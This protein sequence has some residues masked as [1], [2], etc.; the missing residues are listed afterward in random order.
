[1]AKTDG[2]EWLS[3]LENDEKEK[4]TG[5]KG[6]KIK[7]NNVFGYYFDVTNSYKNLVP[8]NWVRKQTTVNSE[9]YTTPELKEL[10]SKILSAQDRLGDIEYELF[11]NT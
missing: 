4:K 9:R 7:Y 6:L 8:D 11:S 2:K 1:M 3:K 10:E 5:I